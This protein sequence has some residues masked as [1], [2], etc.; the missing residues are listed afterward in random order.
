LT[1]RYRYSIEG[2]SGVK[3]KRVEQREKSRV[4]EEWSKEREWSEKEE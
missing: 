1:G 4:K 3:E 2:K